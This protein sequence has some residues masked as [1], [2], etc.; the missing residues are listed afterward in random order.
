MPTPRSTWL[1]PVLSL[2]ACASSD[3]P[4]LALPG[5]VPDVVTGEQ[6][7]PV[8]PVAPSTSIDLIIGLTPRNEGA[9]TEL[10]HDLYDPSS[11]QFHQY[12]TPEQYTT[13]RTTRPPVPARSRR[14]ITRW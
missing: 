3:P 8:A 14:P 6:F 9:R 1:L 11:P 7:E 12:L 5:H 13:A 10:L 4:E 2:A